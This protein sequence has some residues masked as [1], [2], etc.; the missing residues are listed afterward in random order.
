MDD[1]APHLTLTSTQAAGLLEVHPSTVKR[2][3]NDGELPYDTTSGGHRRIRLSD[4]VTFARAKNIVTVLTPFHPY[5]PH[6]WTALCEADEAGSF[7]RLHSLAMGWVHRGRLRRVA[8]L[9]DALAD[10]PSVPLI[11]FL[12]EAVRGLMIDVGRAW[13]EGR[14]RAGEEHMVSQVMTEVLLR[15]RE[16]EQQGRDP[17]S[18]PVGLA[19]VGSAEGN[20][21]HL[22]SLSVRILLERRGW[23]VLYL[24]PDVPLE[25]F[26]MI[27]R[28]RGAGLVCVSLAAPANLG[29]VS[30]TVGLL[31]EFYDHGR[32][33]ALALGGAVPEADGSSVLE[34]L[35]FDDVGLFHD[36]RSFDARLEAGWAAGRVAGV[37]A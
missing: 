12:D 6:V 10:T 33:Y 35:P 8:R 26:A 27:Q 19:L 7:Q 11:R 32:P 13:H 18:P 24:G 36:C 5:E 23:E 37:V 21:H 17:E 29:D 16:R 2:W 3:C 25:D 22:G 31:G 15:L 14:L 20:Q 34:S 4:A 30:R 1:F 28:R 9:F